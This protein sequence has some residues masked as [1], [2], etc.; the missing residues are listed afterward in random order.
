ML[1][2]LKATLQQCLLQCQEDQVTE[3]ISRTETLEDEA[4]K[5]IAETQTPEEVERHI[6]QLL[7]R[8]G[9]KQAITLSQEASR[10]FRKSEPFSLVDP[11]Q[12]EETQVLSLLETIFKGP[13]TP[14]PKKNPQES[15]GSRS[16]GLTDHDETP[17]SEPEKPV[18][19]N[20]LVKQE[21]L[22]QY[23]QDAYN[24]SLKITQAMGII[25]KMMYENTTTGGRLSPCTRSGVSKIGFQPKP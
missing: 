5:E 4:P 6:R 16:P 3:E 18:D 14:S 25:S 20:E 24:F 12:S 22:V 23:L 11:E 9:Y 2:E 10:H 21:M 8:A 17:V 13:T 7:T 19:D 15:A 1:P